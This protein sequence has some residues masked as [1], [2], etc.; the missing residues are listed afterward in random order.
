MGGKE[1]S[2][3]MEEEEKEPR[4]VP[5][6][7]WSWWAGQ[8]K[9]GP[10]SPL[11]PTLLCL[12]LFLW[13]LPPPACPPGSSQDSAV[14]TQAGQC[15]PWARA[16]LRAASETGLPRWVVLPITP[17]VQKDPDQQQ[18]PPPRLLGRSLFKGRVRTRQQPPSRPS[19]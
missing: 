17:V 11:H 13:A 16:S 5:R 14:V 8:S 7:A 19:S 9:V 6:A 4:P 2:E 18:E 10:A 1:V 12:G 3:E 15:F